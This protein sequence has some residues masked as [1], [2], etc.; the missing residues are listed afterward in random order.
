MTNTK[1][2][3]AYDD[4]A[5]FLA[6]FEGTLKAREPLALYEFIDCA[7]GPFR[8]RDSTRIKFVARCVEKCLQLGAVPCEPGGPIYDHDWVSAPQYG[9]TPAEIL[10]NVMA[11]WIAGGAK[12]LEVWTGPFFGLP[13]DVVPVGMATRLAGQ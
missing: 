11:E 13:E 6:D 5:D 2:Y 10:H 7:E 3:G 4:E 9:N 8:L 1:K 12:R